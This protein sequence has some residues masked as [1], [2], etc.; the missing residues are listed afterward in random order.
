MNTIIN[1][2]NLLPDTIKEI[3]DAVEKPM[4]LKEIMN[5][6]EVSSNFEVM[7]VKDVFYNKNHQ[8]AHPTGSII[9][10]IKKVEDEEFC[11]AEKLDC[12]NTEIDMNVKKFIYSDNK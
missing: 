7:A 11:Y 9:K 5:K 1:N 3:I 10:I 8:L 12:K 6:Y 4:S 2:I